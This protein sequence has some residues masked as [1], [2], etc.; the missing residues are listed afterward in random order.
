MA[1]V[2][3]R[4]HDLEFAVRPALVAG[5]AIHGSMGSRQRKSVVMLLHV[6]NRN[7]PSPNCVALLAVR[8]QLALV[9]IGVAIL[10]PFP[11]I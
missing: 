5:V 1:G 9:N 11:D 10:A 3:R 8:T 7:L 2:A 4:R 6:L